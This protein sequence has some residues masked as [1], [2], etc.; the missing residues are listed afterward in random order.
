[1]FNVYEN[2][3]YK[4]KALKKKNEMWRNVIDKTIVLRNYMKVW[5]KENIS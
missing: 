1:M 4:L 2:E 5:E 3:I